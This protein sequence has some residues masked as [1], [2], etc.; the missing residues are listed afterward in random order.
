M[1]TVMPP[2]QCVRICSPHGMEGRRKHVGEVYKHSDA[3]PGS[4][5]EPHHSPVDVP[6]DCSTGVHDVILWH[7][8]LADM[9]VAQM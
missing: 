1:W 2:Q 3:R 6:F 9:L 7:T 4:A 8:L 5:T